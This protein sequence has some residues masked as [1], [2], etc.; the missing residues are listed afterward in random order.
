MG[1]ENSSNQAVKHVNLSYDMLKFEKHSDKI[2]L[3]DYVLCV[4]MLKS[5][6]DVNLDARLNDSFLKLKL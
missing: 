3:Q 4:I 6:G 1:L 5:F 2:Q